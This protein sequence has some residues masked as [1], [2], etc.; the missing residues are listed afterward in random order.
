MTDVKSSNKKKNWDSSI[1]RIG[2]KCY[3]AISSVPH[4]N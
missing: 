1:E 4:A 3:W 2:P